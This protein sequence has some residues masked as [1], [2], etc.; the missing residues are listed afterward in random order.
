MMTMMMMMIGV[1]RP[2]CAQ[3]RLNELSDFLMKRSQRL[4]VVKSYS[5]HIY[6]YI[7]IYIYALLFT[8]YATPLSSLIHTH[9][10][11][12]RLYADNIQEVYIS[13]F[14]ADTHL[15]L[16]QLGDCLSDISGWMTNNKLRLNVNKTDFIIIGTAQQTYSFLPY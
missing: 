7:Y 5:L 14:T 11:D 8:L 16:K 1:L 3:D 12:H 13:L 9:K 10:L 2:L 4:D 15:S 6:I